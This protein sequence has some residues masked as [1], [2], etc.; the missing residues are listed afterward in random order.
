MKKIILL[1]C[2]GMFMAGCSSTPSSGVLSCTS[3]NENEA[4]KSTVTMEMTYKDQQVISQT[5]ETNLTA[6]TSDIYE[7]V[8][9]IAENSEIEY[10]DIPGTTYKKTVDEGTL[11]LKEY[12]TL[13]FQTI[14]KEDFQKVVSYR[15]VEDLNVQDIQASLEEQGFTCTIK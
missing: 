6:Q 9:T 8:K 10:K 4:T 15:Q 1:L 12:V 2:M 13:D 5:A 3:T 14:S 7:Q 11:S